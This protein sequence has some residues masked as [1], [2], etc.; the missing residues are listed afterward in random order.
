M[1]V[2]SAMMRQIYYIHSELAH[3]LSA[4]APSSFRFYVV[5]VMETAFAQP[6]RLIVAQP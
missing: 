5:V 3:F 2:Y 4:K 6:I 1:P